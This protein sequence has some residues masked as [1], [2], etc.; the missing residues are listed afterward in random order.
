MQYLLDPASRA[1]QRFTQGFQKLLWLVLGI[2]EALSKLV[3]TT[4]SAALGAVCIAETRFT[5][6]SATV[7]P[8]AT[9]GAVNSA[10]DNYTSCPCKVWLVA[11]PLGFNKCRGQVLPRSPCSA[12]VFSAEF[13]WV[14][15]CRIASMN[16]AGS[17][18]SCPRSEGYRRRLVPMCDSIASSEDPQKCS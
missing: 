10:I 4:Y 17:F 6:H 1:G 15:Q 16:T 3:R 7:L 5:T 12:A 2:K 13:L 9:E 14:F 11:G 18:G 8:A